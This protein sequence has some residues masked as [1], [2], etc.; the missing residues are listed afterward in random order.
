MY[1]T[2]NSTYLSHFSNMCL[3]S[4]KER[5]TNE[6]KICL[7]NISKKKFIKRGNRKPAKRGKELL[8]ATLF[9]TSNATFVKSE[10]L[11]AA[12]KNVRNE[13]DERNLYYY[14]TSQVE[15]H[16]KEHVVPVLEY[17]FS[18][19]VFSTFALCLSSPGLKF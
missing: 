14:L 6:N 12:C 19:E 16:L 1:P 7:L 17:P 5:K 10:E 4:R 3:R 13:E 15:T 9:G 8:A 11:C 18:D 2:R